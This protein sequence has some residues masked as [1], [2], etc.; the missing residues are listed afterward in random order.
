MGTKI[1]SRSRR[2]NEATWFG[3]YLAFYAGTS[4]YKAV[5]MSN[6]SLII[7][8]RATGNETKVYLLK[9][10]MVVIHSVALHSL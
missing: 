4:V 8:A 2:S 1:Y 5:A 3:V 10:D 7:F 6:E 9:M